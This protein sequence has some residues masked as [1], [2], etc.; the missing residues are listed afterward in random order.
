MCGQLRLQRVDWQCSDA[1][2]V[3]VCGACYLYTSFRAQTLAWWPTSCGTQSVGLPRAGN[4]L[5]SHSIRASHCSG[6]SLSGPGVPAAVPRERRLFREFAEQAELTT[7]PRA[8]VA[9]WQR[10]EYA[11]V[12]QLWPGWWW[13]E[14]HCGEH[15]VHVM[16][17]VKDPGRCDRTTLN[18]IVRC[19]LLGH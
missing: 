8:L 3:T 2:S 16:K 1:T 11:F 17:Y 15:G 7:C 14:S 19:C 18:F 12:W 10:G 6:S 4:V 9:K 5:E 13:C